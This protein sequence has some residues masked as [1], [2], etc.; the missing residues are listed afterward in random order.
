[1]EGMNAG[2]IENRGLLGTMRRELGTGKVV[3][4][5]LEDA[6]YYGPITIGTPPQSFEVIFDTGSSNLWVP[7]KNCSDCGLHHKYDPSKSSTYIP[8]GTAWSILYGSGPVSGFLSGDVVNVGG[9]SVPA[10]VFA[11]VDNATGLGLA[12]SIGKFDGILGMG[13]QSISVDNIPTIFQQMVAEGALDAPIFG[14]YLENTGQ[15]G[16]LALGFADTAHYTGTPVYVPVTSE[17]YWESQLNSVSVGSLVFAETPK[18]IFDTGTSLLAGPS[19]DIKKLADAIG[20]KPLFLNPMEYTIPCTKVAG[21]PDMTFNIQAA[22]GPVQFNLT[23]TDYI[24]N[25]ENL[26]E[27]CL[28]GFVGIDVPAPYGPLWIAGDIFLRKYYSIFDFGAGRV[29]FALAKA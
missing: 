13:F 10:A 11:E 8:N 6:Q 24:L 14:V 29:G 22:S 28:C 20:C 18:V 3:I 23:A 27:E 2:V 15:N 16:E 4:K 17:T 7:S 25:V 1:M 12:Y 9:V 21:L 26:N 19:A 5:E